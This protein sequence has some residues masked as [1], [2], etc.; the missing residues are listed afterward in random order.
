MDQETWTKVDDYFQQHLLPTDE[1]L[2]AA[3]RASVEAGLPAISVT[4]TQGKLLI[5][6]AQL[7]RAT[8]ILE[9]GTLGGYSTIWLARALPSDGRLISLEIDPARAEL[10][11]ANLARAGFT[12]NVEVRFGSAADSLDVLAK[13][14]ARFDFVFIDADKRSTPVYFD[15]AVRLA[16]PGAVVVVDNVVRRGAVAD[17]NTTNADVVGIRSF[18]ESLEGHSRVTATAVQTV[19]GKGY[20]GFVVATVR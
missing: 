2:D 4:P 7:R 12:S 5:M 3:H 19:G 15:H 9:I 18:I 13:E 6:L 17:A 16:M 8:S 11:R 14:Q 1:A 20:D 10:A